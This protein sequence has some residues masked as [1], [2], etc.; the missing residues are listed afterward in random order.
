MDCKKQRLF[1]LSTKVDGMVVAYFLN[2]HSG[3][4]FNAIQSDAVSCLFST[5][6]TTEG[7]RMRFAADRIAA[8]TISLRSMCACKTSINART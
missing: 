3:M 4:L 7:I 2:S 6:L 1:G 5:R 8:R